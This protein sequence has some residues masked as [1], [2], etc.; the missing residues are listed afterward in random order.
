MF[1]CRSKISAFLHRGVLVLAQCVPIHGR[2]T[3]V[4]Q[5]KRSH[6]LVE[7]Q[8]KFTET[9]IPLEYLHRI[10]H[11]SQLILHQNKSNVTAHFAPE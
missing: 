7:K 2:L 11:K 6:L 10:N 3:I 9:S 1:L 5:W 4:L 8:P